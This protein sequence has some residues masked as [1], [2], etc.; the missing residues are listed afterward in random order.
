MKTTK[1]LLIAVALLGFAY[2]MSECW[3][4][5]WMYHG[6]SGTPGLLH[7]FFPVDGEGSYDL[8]F[9][10][11]FIVCIAIC[12]LGIV[13]L[14]HLRFQKKKTEPNKRLESNAAMP[15]P[16]LGKSTAVEHRLRGVSQP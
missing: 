4:S 16:S 2:A 15:P 7:R 8:T 13:A 9:V 6:W 5:L 10:E 11:M 12:V 3:W 14:T 1:I